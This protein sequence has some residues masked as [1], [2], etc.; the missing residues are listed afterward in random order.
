MSFRKK[1]NC[2]TATKKKKE[3]RRKEERLVID[4]YY[5]GYQ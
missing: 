5:V 1:T 3:E 2:L 4:K